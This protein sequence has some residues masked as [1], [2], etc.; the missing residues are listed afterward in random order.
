ME[1]SQSRVAEKVVTALNAS[2]SARQSTLRETNLGLIARTVCGSPTPMSRADVAAATSMTRSTVSRLVDELVAGGVLSEQLPATTTGPGRPGT[3]L[4]AGDQLGAMGLQINATY[5]AVR[6]LD[7]SGRVVAERLEYGDFVGS[8]PEPTL[9]RLAELASSTLNETP[10]LRMVGARLALPGVV[11]PDTGHLLNAPNLGWSDVKPAR[12]LGD[13]FAVDHGVRAGN[14]AELAARTVAET[15]PGRSSGLTDF[16]YLSGEIGIGGAAVVDGQVFP[17]RH[18]WAGEIGH[19]C[20]DPNGPPCPCGSTGC[21]ERYAGRHALLASAGLPITASP[22]EIIERAVS[23]DEI[24]RQAI[25]GAVEAL[26]VALSSVINIL[27]IS[28]VVLGGH[29]GQIASALAPDLERRLARRVLSAR[30]VAPVVRAAETDPAAGATGAAMVELAA[31][32]ASPVSWLA[33]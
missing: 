27:D 24:A 15:A 5:L 21:L 13:T 26:S 10:P 20:V 14:E 3:P 28:T 25:A 1:T 7:L 31:V 8:A 12:I 32:L 11:S 18:G 23:G 2:P 17:G 4:V 33:S 16:I 30:W 22:D 19:V 29:L 9:R 6:I